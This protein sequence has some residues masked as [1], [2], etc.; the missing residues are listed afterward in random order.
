MEE[1]KEYTISDITEE[2]SMGPFGSNIKVDN[3]IDFGIP[4]LNGSNLQGHKLNEESFNYVSKEKADSLG[5]ANAYRGDVVITHRG[6]LGQIVYIPNDSKF[7]RYVISQSQ[8]RLKLDTSIVRPDFF[9]YYFHTREGQHK[10]LMNASQVGVP[11]LA[12]PTSTF[13]KVSINLPSLKTQN[14]IMDVVLALDDKIENNRK[15]NENLEQQAQ[16]LFKSWFVDFEPFRDQPFVDSELG[17]IPQGWRVV[18]LDEACKKITD[19][20]HYSPKDNTNG[21]IPMLSVKDM[22]H[23]D[24]DYSSCKRIDEDEFNKMKKNDCVPL[25][26]DIL[27]AKDGSYLKEIFI[28]NDETPKAVLSSIAIF[29]SNPNVIYPELLL[30]LLRLPL[31][32]K[33]VGDNYVSGSALPR[34]VLKDF[35]KFKFVIAPI[36]VQNLI[37]VLFK[38]LQNQIFKNEL[39]IRSLTT[40]RDTLLPKLMSGEIKV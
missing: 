4:V 17:P 24:F 28:C 10:I 38:A 12:R 18:T 20:S 35:K 15:I 1:W 7:E 40:L 11:A 3:F 5:K 9:V 21:V 8:F 39:E 23:N 13:K 19:G 34:I 31:V 37:I 22:G 36:D 14:E 16:A 2:I 33:D 25:I 30:Q 6:T 27:V 32:K 29:R 26:D